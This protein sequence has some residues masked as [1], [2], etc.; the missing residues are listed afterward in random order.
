[1]IELNYRKVTVGAIMWLAYC[2]LSGIDSSHYV[3][4]IYDTL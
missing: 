3:I 1:M 2:R 4:I